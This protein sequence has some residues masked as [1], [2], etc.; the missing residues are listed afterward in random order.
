MA[1]SNNFLQFDPNKNNI[2]GDSDY[3]SSSYRQNG[4]QAGVA[5]SLTHN[6]LFYQVSTMTAALGA[7]MAA[8]GY[9]ISDADIS[10]LITAFGNIMTKADM[11]PY[12]TTLAMEAWVEAYV[13][14]LLSSLGTGGIKLTTFSRATDGG[15]GNVS[16]TGAGFKPKAIIVATYDLYIFGIISIGMSDFSSQ[17][18][19]AA[20]SAPADEEVSRFWGSSTQIVPTAPYYIGQKATVVSSD[21]DG[22]TLAWSNANPHSGTMLGGI[23][24]FK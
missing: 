16:Y 3:N 2:Q 21:A 11:T 14:S 13:A 20:A 9:T 24:Y 8:K 1:G 23:L 12:S 4:C 7:A 19:I 10:A 15:S 22:C 5:P 17:F 6:K 18:S